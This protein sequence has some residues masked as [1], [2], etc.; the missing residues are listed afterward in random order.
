MPRAKAAKQAR[1]TARPII[2]NV[3]VVED[4][5]L[6]ALDIEQNLRD[7]GAAL[8]QLCPSTTEALALLREHRFDAIVLDVHLADRSDG[9]AIAELVDSVGPRPPRIGFSTGAPQDIPAGIAELGIVLAK[10]YHPQD[11][12]RAV[13]A[14]RR[15]GLLARLRALAA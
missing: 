8:V 12:V 11:L 2:G 14:P 10:P 3:L 13:S 7:A 9:W 4:D 6:L 5:A 15:R 1:P